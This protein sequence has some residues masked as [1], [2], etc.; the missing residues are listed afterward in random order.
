MMRVHGLT[1]EQLGAL[2][3]LAAD[4]QGFDDL[5]ESPSLRVIVGGGASRRTPGKRVV[6]E[7][8]VVKQ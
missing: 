2:M 7:L 6:P 4:N 3:R 8:V 5:A 1:P